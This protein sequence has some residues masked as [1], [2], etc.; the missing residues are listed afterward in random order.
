MLVIIAGSR[1]CKQTDVYNAIFRCPW[2]KYITCVLSGGARGAD[3]FGELWAK[4]KELRVV[5]F[6][7]QWDK[8]GKKAGI[9]RNEKMSKVA[10]GLIA[11]WDGESRGTRAMIGLAMSEGLRVFVFYTDN[12]EIE[13]H[14]ALD[15]LAYLW[16]RAEHCGKEW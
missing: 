16:A 5:K 12:G 2:S 8:F 9:L 7:A 13:E 11:V 1:S 15:E 3:S 14:P 6:P 4:E 10:H